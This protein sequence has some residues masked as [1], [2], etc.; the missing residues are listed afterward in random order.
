[1]TTLHKFHA[2]CHA[3][4]GPLRI[5]LATLRSPLKSL[6]IETSVY[7]GDNLSAS[8]LHDHLGHLVLTLHVLDLDYFPLDILPSSVTIRFTVIRSLKFQTDYIPD[9]DTLAILLHLFPNLDGILI[10]G[11]LTSNLPEDVHLA[12]RARSE[13]AQRTHIWS[14]LDL[15]VCNAESAFALALRCPIRRMDSRVPRPCSRRYLADTLR[16]GNS[17]QHL[18]LSLSFRLGVGSHYMGWSSQRRW[19]S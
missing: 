17:P 9:S 4:W 8:F 5:C 12:M 1:M 7:V 14:G 3:L 10:L 15:L 11:F 18:Y 16:H 13:E 19:K 6:C 2:V